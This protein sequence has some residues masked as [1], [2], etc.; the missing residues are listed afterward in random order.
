MARDKLSDAYSFLHISRFARGGYLLVFVSP[1]DNGYGRPDKAWSLLY[2]RRLGGI[3]GCI[4]TPHSATSDTRRRQVS[5]LDGS[6]ECVA[7]TRTGRQAVVDGVAN[8][9]KQARRADVDCSLIC[10]A[11]SR[12]CITDS[13]SL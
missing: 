1:P 8:R 4:A 10:I 2:F 11:R 13:D 3:L 9:S 6:G 5:H 7:W 12:N